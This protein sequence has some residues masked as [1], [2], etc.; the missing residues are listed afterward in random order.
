MKM[1]KSILATTLT[2]I[3]VTT[4]ALAW[5]NGDLPASS[6]IFGGSIIHEQENPWQWNI[7]KPLEGLNLKFKDGVSEGYITTFKLPLNE[8]TLLI[9]KTK[10]EITSGAAG[11]APYVTFTD[12][13]TQQPLVMTNDS[14]KPGRSVVSLAVGDKNNSASAS[15]SASAG[16]FQFALASGLLLGQ[17]GYGSGT[18]ANEYMAIAKAGAGSQAN[19]IPTHPDTAE[20]TKKLI[21]NA[22][23]GIGEAL[24]NWPQMNIP[25]GGAGSLETAFTDPQRKGMVSAYGAT[26]LA[27]DGI[28]KLT[29]EGM[30][31]EWKSV[32]SV[33]VTHN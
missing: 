4:P 12:G 9:G 15:A 23:S 14:N 3:I 26:M 13:I 7:G 11:L 21:S 30:P 5:T 17:A 16:T 28:V 22:F 2:T 1:K 33:S 19:G 8:K 32:L 6:I 20:N 31:S 24:P 25:L 27:G 10:N 18:P 29:T